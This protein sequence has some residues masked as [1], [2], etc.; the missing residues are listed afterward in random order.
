MVPSTVH[1]A[2]AR[3]ETA[4]GGVAL[5]VRRISPADLAD[6]LKAGLSDFLRHP[7]Q[8][9]FLALIYPIV[10]LFLARLSFGQD[11]LPL[12]FPLV[13]G[14]ALLG[15]LTAV[16]LYEMSRRREEGLPAGWDH[17]FALAHSPAILSI[18]VIGCVLLAT[19]LMWLVAALVIYE[20]TLGSYVPASLTAFAREIFETREGWRLIVLGN[21]V[22]LGFAV[23]AM[24]LSVVSLPL[25]VD[26]DVSTATAVRTSFSAVKNNP[27][28][29]ALW[30]LIVA[31][32]LALGAL[33]FF[34]G[35][36]VVLPILGHA[37][38]HLYR[39]LVV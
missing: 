8:L 2:Y 32:L 37:T 36:A 18:A 27:V 19:F 1:P 24:C 13:A 7:S 31:A 26:R 20:A 15:P 30:G 21:G 25:L 3:P 17:A 34:V 23:F 11:V 4:F 5:R 28:V 16:G 33:P 9:I 39:R 14:F 38:W 29:M 10:G 6:C 12:L 35:L 22:G